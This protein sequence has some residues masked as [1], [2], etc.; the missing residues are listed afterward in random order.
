MLSIYSI[1]YAQIIVYLILIN[2]LKFINIENEKFNLFKD[3]YNNHKNLIIDFIISYIILKLSEKY[4]IKNLP[5]IYNR[6][7]MIIIFDLILSLYIRYTSFD[8][9]YLQFLKKWA[10]LVGWFA[11]LWDIIYFLSIGKIADKINNIEIIKKYSFLIILC[12]GFILLHL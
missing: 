7:L 9:N 12:F 6:I 2:L 11:I 3:Y 10:N 1:L 8:S 4:S 5:K